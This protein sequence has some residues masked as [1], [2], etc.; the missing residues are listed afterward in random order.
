MRGDVKSKLSHCLDLI[1]TTYHESGHVVYG[2]LHLM[3][4][5]SVVVFENKDIN[6]IEGLTSYRSIDIT[7]ITDIELIDYVLKSDICSNYAGLISEKLLFKEI[8]GSDKLP[9]FIKDGSSKDTLEAA[10]IIRKYKL[11]EPGKKRYSLKKKL[12]KETADELLLF[13][14]DVK[15]VAYEL[16]KHKKLMSDD[17]KKIL[18]TKSKN[19]KIWKK[20]F[21]FIDCIYFNMPAID[22]YFIKSIFEQQL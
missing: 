9:F 16:Y 2:L 15:L 4:V 8:S 3:I 21:K 13:W 19:K 5:D 1:S 11:A 10:K 22:E 18:T 7:S 14:E 12:I 6:R 17:I 20:K